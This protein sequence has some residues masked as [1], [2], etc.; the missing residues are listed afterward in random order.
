M[1]PQQW[2]GPT[3]VK[4]TRASRSRSLRLLLCLWIGLTAGTAAYAQQNNTS[5]QRL[6]DIAASQANPVDKTYTSISFAPGV[7]WKPEQAQDIFREYM[8]LG[9][10]A[11]MSFTG[12]TVT[13]RGLRTDRYVQYYKGIKVA[14]SSAAVLCKGG[15]VSSVSS[16]Y[17]APATDLATTPALSE[18]KA[19]SKALAHV[20]AEKYLWQQP[21]PLQNNQKQLGKSAADSKPKGSLMWIE[22]MTTEQP[23]RQLHLA[24]AFNIYAIKPLSNDVV[25]VDAQT[26]K[27]LFVNPLLKNTA[28]T[29]SSLYSGTVGF[30][31]SLSGSN[32]VLED[33]T[34]GDGVNT[35]TCAGGDGSVAFHVTSATTSFASDA[36]ID[37][38]WGAEKVYDYWLNEQGRNS[39]DNA[40]AEIN[41]FV[42]FLSGY[43][44]AFWDGYEMV[45][46]D[47][48]G[49]GS[50]GFSPLTSLDV[51]AHEIGHAVCQYTADLVY[52]K[53]PGAMNEGFSD[54]WGAVIE[55]YAN[56]HETDA[57]AKDKW[58]IGEEISASSLRRMDNPNLKG[59]PDTYGGTYWV[60]V[61]GCTP[62]S[63]NDYCGVH[64]NSG[65]L[66]YW[67][68]LLVQG[69]SGTNDI[70]NAF[71]VTGIGLTKGADIAY[72]TELLLTSSSTYA[73]CRTASIN[74][75]TALYGACSPEVAAVTKAWYA[76]GVGA[77]YSGST[78]SPITGT[79]TVCSG[80]ATTLSNA[81]SSGVWSSSNSAVATVGSATGIVTGIAAGT[82]IISYTA[83]SC[84]ATE[85]VTVSSATAGS[86]AG[87]ASV[88]EGSSITLG[89]T[90]SGGTW[91]S[92]DITVATAGSAT[93]IITGVSAGMATI[94]YT[95][96]TCGTS[97]TTAS[98]SVNAL[99]AAIGGT[100]SMCAGTTTTL[101]NATSGGTWGSSAS[102][103]A[104]VDGSTGIIT[105]VAAGTS[106]IT[107]TVSGC[108]ATA[109]ATVIAASPAPITGAS[110]VG[111]ASSILLAN[112]NTG[113]TWSSSDAL[114]ASVGSST[115]IVSGVSIGA[116]TITYE[117]TNSCGTF[118]ST[119]AITVAC[120]GGLTMSTILGTGTAGNGTSGG[121]GTSTAVNLPWGI[122]ADAAG[123]VY[124]CDFENNKIRKV[125]SSGVATDFAG[126]GAYGFSGD[127]GPAVTAQI[128]SPTGLA[129]HGTD[130][131]FIDFGN[132]RI[133]KI[134]AS[135]TITTV[136]GNG[137]GGYSGD[138]G[139]ATAASIAGPNGLY[140]DAAGNIY[141]PDQF[142]NRIRKVNTS[143]IITTIA[144]DGS[145]A[146]TG[147]GGPATSAGLQQPNDVIADNAG[148]I[149]IT[150]YAGNRI[151]KIDGATGI[152]TTYAGTGSYGDSGDGGAASSALTNGP[153]GMSFDVVG[154]L[155][156]CDV[157]NHRIRKVDATTGII[158]TI[159]GTGTA[160]Y[161]GDGGDPTLAKLNRPHRIGA[162]DAGNLYISDADDNRVRKISAGTLAIS[163]TT[164][165]CNGQSATLA[166]TPT[167]GTWSSSDIA[168]ATIDGTTGVV[169]GVA[170]GTALISYELSASCVATA[171]ITVTPEVTAI[172][173]ST[174]LCLGATETFSNGS[175]GGT[176]SSTNTT[177]ATI[178]S[179]SG[180][181]VAASLGTTTISYVNGA[182]AASVTATV[183]PSS[184]GSITGSSSLFAGATTT[185]TS[186]VAGGAWSSDNTA[187]ATVGS[188]SGV[189]TAVATGTATIS[190]VIA[191]SCGT[192]TATKVLTVTCSSGETI[193]TILGT[194]TAGNGG[195]GGMGTSTAI[196]MPWGIRADAAGNVYV[197]DFWNDKVRKISPSGVVTNYAG[198]GTSG[199]S[200]DGGP[201]TS[202]SLNGPTGMAINDS[203]V[204]FVDIF[205]GRVRKVNASGIISTIAGGGGSSS[206][207]VPATTANLGSPNG[208]YIDATGNIY[209]PDQ[210]MNRVRKINTSGIISTI[211][212]NG[213]YGY[214]GDGGPALSAQMKQPNGVI[215]DAAGNVYVSEYAGNRVRRIDATTGIITTYAGNGTAG[216]GGDGGP[217]TS[218]ILNGPAGMAFD[219]Y[220]NLLIC[221]VENHRV[222]RV[223]ATTGIITTYAGTGA[224]GYSGD[225]GA[226]GAAM[227]KRPA[228][229]GTDPAG[230]IYISDVADHRV[231]KITV[232]SVGIS[233]VTSLCVGAGST[234]T[235]TPGGG[236]WSSSNTAVATVG[237]STGIVSGISSGTAAITYTTGGGCTAVAIVSV[238]TAVTGITGSSA[239]CIG[240][241]T[242][243]SN[244]T[245]S[246][247]W[248]SG[249]ATAT[250]NATTGVVT[251][252]SAG[253]AT[254]SYTIG[255]CAATHVISVSATPPAI[256]GTMKACAG[257]TSSLSNSISGGVWTSSNTAVATINSS[258]GVATGVA[259][260]TT[261][262]SYGV[263]GSCYRTGI[264][265]VNATP[266][267]IGGTLSA[268]AGNTTVV[269]NTTSGGVSWTSSDASV[270][271]VGSTS[272]L[273]T[274]VSAGT[275]T[276][277][278]TVNTGCY[279]TAIFT[280]TAAPGAINGASTVC[281]GSTITL[282][283]TTTG[284]TW[285]S[286]AT[287]VAT[288]GSSTG[289]L[290][291]VNG[292]VA[293]ITY[294]AGGC[295]VTKSVTVSAIS[296]I[297]GSTSMC[298]GSSVTLANATAG[299]A[300]SSS[301]AAIASVGSGTGIVTGVA[302]GTV[303]ITYTIPSGCSR[304]IIVTVSSTPVTIGG[305]LSVCPGITSTLTNATAGGAWN[306]SN[307]AV[308]SINSTT[309]VL[310]GVAPGTLNIS[311]TLSGGCRAI[312]V[313]TVN[314]LPANMGGA[315]NVCRDQTTT[316]T[317]ASTGGAWSSNNTA[318]ATI[319]AGTGIA[320]GI[321]TGTTTITYTL[322]TG[323][324][325]A[326]PF[327]VKA[328]P[329]AIG[330]SLNVCTTTSAVLSNTTSG[331]VSW[332]SS[333]PSVA[334]IGIYSGLL[335]GVSAGTSTITYTVNTGCFI[336][337]VATVHTLPSAGSITGPSTVAVSNTITLANAATGGVWSSSHPSRAAV[338]VDGVVTGVSGGTATISYT[339]SNAGCTVRSTKAISVTLSRPGSPVAQSS[340][341]SLQLYPNPTTGTF[342]IEAPEAGTFSIYTLDGKEVSSY[343]IAQ[344]ATVISLPNE[345]A[346]GI[347]MC[348]YYGASGS[349]T[350]VRLV[351][352]H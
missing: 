204:Y 318:I 295:K 140:V 160:G 164:S 149:F 6:R 300:W 273:V 97:T 32:Y 226:P 352:E 319:G 208:L 145:Y 235:G 165:I 330:G 31:A 15:L 233:G 288:I 28:A 146:S 198:T 47:G 311:Y 105:G 196:N 79:A 274:G 290:T 299:G 202:G 103:I 263:G 127:G 221:D 342:T 349:T 212:G 138:G 230:N 1:L 134:D 3:A 39:F 115:G 344:G 172:S 211:G 317:N 339:V 185:Y 59:Q 112:V 331:G 10:N 340:L 4:T 284:G 114:I 234:L 271:T 245:A 94:T 171:T 169:T 88:C 321:A 225:G 128:A 73:D 66:N 194:G 9:S 203:G 276:I 70:S 259:A 35:Y 151:R 159:A 334:T 139:P 251:G 119:K 168:V 270:A 301:D 216:Y 306:G 308:A 262:I 229:I 191:N 322:P 220:G 304:T 99:P 326:V 285:T 254:I 227:L 101:T 141:I 74:A 328:L 261:T 346:N 111:L 38:H 68:Y 266:A 228:R 298:I 265:T 124:V 33:V 93:G 242:T 341:G 179:S 116:A 333:S 332:T 98:I 247:A 161:S 83:G 45:Y 272:G 218:S 5:K 232:G 296:A 107:Y 42:H 256:T 100:L 82:A 255:S 286:S 136:A 87:S 102:A 21:A 219:M 287:S 338:D 199:F 67:F 324:Y 27:I 8:G 153:G 52:N 86:I 12:T 129:V 316:I 132:A 29:G 62:G 345:L 267:A 14:M 125:D 106:T 162:D 147:D 252:V 209:I 189:V 297:S 193:S 148:N 64:T 275:A 126:T 71:S 187:V 293:T 44:N 248:T 135:G 104:S 2:N 269:T 20:G 303:T 17:F 237:T 166:A 157:E 75:A 37:A 19:L 178:G 72:Q 142:N 246:G 214:S 222:R 77:N 96:T 186:S 137:A 11:T 260:G 231:R 180:I 24:Y 89:A 249:S 207:G 110:T 348:R 26:G 188:A 173:G 18:A 250:V 163:G 244:G 240:S 76:V 176:W 351:Y 167:G 192:F 181:A 60:S 30:Q 327:T 13:K 43:N 130:V 201:A 108:Y 65:V 320:T 34:R 22:D 205:N 336:T 154:N 314:V 315:L 78:V 170:A 243:L 123:N 177:A 16:N 113:G 184:A 278:Y 91:S 133:R 257:T 215:A 282:T 7:K 281:A 92:G 210:N 258:T 175:T 277:T 224:Y 41:S 197:C 337:A 174:T 183:I 61:T 310:T 57:V 294:N 238:S 268:C 206:D 241:T 264:F 117:F 217:S 239:V 36:A 313:A 53:E 283:N 48:S 55:E 236:T 329:A 309:G 131:Y 305:T 253:T 291:G 190:Y 280:V 50:G 279:R 156:F 144:G 292:G 302:G 325:R 121:A 40:G 90:V 335:T 223:D 307:A 118:A 343:T 120:S 350:V 213:T 155:L 109:V 150:E 69:G 143:G 323:C 85:I 80:A 347:Y 195:S 25:Y 84:S 54:I 152:I 58:K 95:T 81:T 56:P 63:G 49:I 23:D 46:G 122:R 200:G 182:C 289:I 312:T 158:S 51:C